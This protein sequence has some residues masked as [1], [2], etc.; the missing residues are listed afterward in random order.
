MSAVTNVE[1][2]FTPYTGEAAKADRVDIVAGKVRVL[3]NNVPIA[4]KDV[5]ASK[6]PVLFEDR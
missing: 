6:A 1:F 2:T 4:E 3:L 5:P